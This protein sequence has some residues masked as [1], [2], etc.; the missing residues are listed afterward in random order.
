MR[1]K[2]AHAFARGDVLAKVPANKPI[3]AEALRNTPTAVDA[4]PAFIHGAETRG[5]HTY[6]TLGTY[7]VA[8][9][10]RDTDITLEDTEGIPAMGPAY[11]LPG[12]SVRK[13]RRSESVD[14]KPH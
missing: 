11:V 7:G 6:V 2:P 13:A 1:V 3:V 4:D 5:G 10:A 8:R 14:A 12:T 9:V